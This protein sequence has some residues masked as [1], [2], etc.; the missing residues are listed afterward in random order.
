MNYIVVGCPWWATLCS[1]E[2][3]SQLNHHSFP[4]ITLWPNVSSW[5]H[6]MGLKTN[7]EGF[8]G[9]Y[10]DEHSVAAHTYIYIYIWLLVAPRCRYCQNPFRHSY[11][12]YNKNGNKIVVKEKERIWLKQ[13]LLNWIWFKQDTSPEVN[14]AETI[15]WNP[16]VW[17]AVYKK[18]LNL[19]LVTHFTLNYYGVYT[20]TWKITAIWLA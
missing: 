6:N 19:I 1:D 2:F 20:T 18:A 3:P 10:G 16:G 4:Y 9:S 8:L 17:K 7:C 15:W 5:L 13:I 12:S 11:N 14:L